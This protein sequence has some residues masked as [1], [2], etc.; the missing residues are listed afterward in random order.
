MPNHY[1]NSSAIWD[2]IGLPSTQQMG[3]S[4]LYPRQS[5]LVLALEG[6]KAK[7]TIKKCIEPLAEQTKRTLD[8]LQWFMYSSPDFRLHNLYLLR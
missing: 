7:L 6:C 8:A 5:M 2:N 3:Y 4:R 1:E